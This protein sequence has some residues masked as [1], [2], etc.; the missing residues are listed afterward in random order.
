MTGIRTLDRPRGLHPGEHVV[1]AMD[2]DSALPD[3]LADFFHEGAERGEQ[4][5]FICAGGGDGVLAGWC[6]LKAWLDDGRLVVQ[7]VADTYRLAATGQPWSQVQHFAREVEDARL[8]GYSGIRVWADVTSLVCDPQVRQRLLDYETAVDSLFRRQAVTGVC[9][10]DVGDSL[11]HWTTLSARHRVRRTWPGACEFVV[12]LDGGTVYLT[13][14]LD[15][16]TVAELTSALVTAARTTLGPLV[17]DLS[18]TRFVDATGA[19][20]IARFVEGLQSQGRRSAVRGVRGVSADVLAA[21][22]LVVE[23][24]T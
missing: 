2:D 14:E 16:G 3:A 9:A 6:E 1:W 20:A 7:D 11:E 4:M 19:R 12:E 22:G 17:V 13:G 15:L 23:D 5:I 10:I 18:Q 24:L 8:D 21:F